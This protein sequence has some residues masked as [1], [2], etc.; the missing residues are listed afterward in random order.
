LV[1]PSGL[2]QLV[3]VDM[4]GNGLGPDQIA[5]SGLDVRFGVTGL[6]LRPK[7]NRRRRPLR[8]LFQEA[9]VP[10]WWRQFVPLIFQCG[11]LA[12]VAGLDGCEAF[13]ADAAPAMRVLW[14]DTP[15]WLRSRPLERP[16][17]EA[18][19]DDR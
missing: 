12:A 16:L 13:A 6:S 17:P 2:G 8:K 9:G 3:L 18:V 19:D 7:D 5:F 11:Q 4:D 10:P 1:L 15:D 14:L